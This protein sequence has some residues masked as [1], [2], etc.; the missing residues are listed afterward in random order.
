MDAYSPT[1]SELRPKNTIFPQVLTY[2]STDGLCFTILLTHPGGFVQQELEGVVCGLRGLQLGATQ[3]YQVVFHM[4]VDPAVQGLEDRERE[5]PGV[6]VK[7]GLIQCNSIILD[8][9]VESTRESG[10]D[11]KS[12]TDR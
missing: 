10:G 5:G 1:V 12:E 2:M 3:L 4:L 7:N 6:T 9:K 8:N 11:T